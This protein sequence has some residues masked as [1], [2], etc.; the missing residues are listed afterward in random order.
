MAERSSLVRLQ[1]EWDVRVEWNGY[2]LHPETPPGGLPL[3]AYLPNA[4]G[5]LRHVAEFASRF[6]IADLRPPERV[7]NTRR[8]LAL[9]EHARDLS[10]LEEL[11]AAAF[12]AYWR[13]GWCLEA[14]GDLRAVAR[15]AGLD[16]D[17]ALAAAGS[18]ALLAR[19]DGARR[20]AIDAGVTGVPTFDVGGTRVVGCQPY[21]VLAAA[22]RRAGAERR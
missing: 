8:V 2:E 22:A 4:E 16:P 7:A 3:A 17:A 1:R 6:G 15:A 5:M 21:E 18:P 20:R 19:V 11:R 13:H 9:A 10:R 14:D 12:D